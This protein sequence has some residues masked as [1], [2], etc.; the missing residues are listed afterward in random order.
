MLANFVQIFTM[1]LSRESFAV[2]Y[3]AW[4]CMALSQVLKSYQPLRPTVVTAQKRD[5]IE[6]L[7]ISCIHKLLLS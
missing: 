5:R 7:F 2:V 3:I 4:V 1:D 6:C